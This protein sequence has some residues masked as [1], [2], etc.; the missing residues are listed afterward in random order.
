[1]KELLKKYVANSSVALHLHDNKGLPG[2]LVIGVKIVL[3]RVLTSTFIR[4]TPL[5]Q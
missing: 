4:A 3:Y 2:Y 5:I 1:M